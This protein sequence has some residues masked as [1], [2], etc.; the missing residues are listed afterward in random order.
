MARWPGGP[1]D[2]RSTTFHW[3][4][5]TRAAPDGAEP[6]PLQ[7]GDLVAGFRVIRELGAGGMGMVWEAEQ[8][9]PRRRVALKTIAPD[10]WSDS[11]RQRFRFE[12]EAMGSLLHP[13]IPQIYA[14][15]EDRGRLFLAMEKVDGQRLDH[16]VRQSEP[17]RAQVCYL[18]IEICDAVHHAHMRGLVH[19]DLKPSNIL[20]LDSG[21][22]KVLDFGIARAHGGEADQGKTLGTPAY[23]SPERVRGEQVDVRTD[24]WSLGVLAYKLL[25]GRAP[26]DLSG[27]EPQ[28]KLHAVQRQPIP[29]LGQLDRRLK[30][31]LEAI[32]A[33]ALE[34][35]VGRRYPSAQA[36]ADDLRRCLAHEPVRARPPTIAYRTGRWLRRNTRLS[37]ALVLV[38]TALT[39][40]LGVAWDSAL[41]AEAARAAE[42]EQRWA[43]EA[44]LERAEAERARALATSDFLAG[45]VELAHPDHSPGHEPTIAEALDRARQRLDA[46]VLADQPEVEVDV[47]TTMAGVYRGVSRMEEHEAMLEAAV[48]LR[49]AAGPTRAGARAALLLADLRK[50]VDDERA[51]RLL[52]QAEQDVAR[53]GPDTEELQAEL[54]HVAG[55]VHRAAGRFAASEASFRQAIAIHEA[56]GGS[57]DPTASWNQLGHTLMQVGRAEE[58]EALYERALAYDR[59]RWGEE[60]PQVATDLLNAGRAAVMAGR[61]EGLQTLA[62]AL[63]L[64]KRALGPGH[65][66][67]RSARMALADA[68]LDYGRID[69]AE[70]LLDAVAA[71]DDTAESTLRRAHQLRL[72][73]RVALARGRLEAAEHSARTALELTR[74][75]LEDGHVH[76]QRPRIVLAEIQRARG[77]L[78][79]AR[80]SL[81]TALR[82]LEATAGPTASTTLRA[83]ELLREL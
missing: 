56:V 57:L 69:R 11:A 75:E 59:V 58:A 7:P 34:R 21:L 71:Q 37:L 62:R 51:L 43:T 18:L 67:T 39:V 29:P 26:L 77:D 49:D 8:D 33:R 35:D 48:A 64:R 4:Q 14:A 3:S 1:I 81:R 41:E 40:G 22:P 60:H 6:A 15:G 65:R 23:M 78:E 72:M 68:M 44:A 80:D 24:V 82:H 45:L 47:R 66:R 32:V 2:L 74:Q 73:A 79:G 83:R 53:L 17:T 63:E 42:A 5:A 30:G 36:L 38:F 31:D 61:E 70:E 28:Q 27:L 10:R 46:G 12:A 13:G 76:T 9:H 25:G 54:A 50:A 19:R 52:A 20:V 16:W 55:R